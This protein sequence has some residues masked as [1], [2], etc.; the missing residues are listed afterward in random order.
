MAGDAQNEKPSMLDKLK[1]KSL[2]GMEKVKSG[3]AAVED[4]LLFASVQVRTGQVRSLPSFLGKIVAKLSYGDRVRVR[5]KR[6][7]W[8]KITVP[9]TEEDGWMHASALSKKR[10][11]LDPGAADVQEEATSEELALAGKGFNQ[12][13]EGAFKA[14]HQDLDYSVIDRMEEIVISSEQIVRFLEEGELTPKEES[15]FSP[16]GGLR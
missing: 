11:I 6:G 7:S 1:E 2:E 12:E 13:V 10:I 15:L 16:K 8:T 5:E 3:Y 9:D 4:K 14:N